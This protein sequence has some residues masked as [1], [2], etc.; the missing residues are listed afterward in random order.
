MNVLHNELQPVELRVQGSL[1]FFDTRQGNA[2]G[3]VRPFKTTILEKSHHDP[4]YDV[5]WL[6]LGKTGSECVSSS[7]DG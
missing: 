2:Q 5:Y 7:T 3:V 6:T 1:S 4:V